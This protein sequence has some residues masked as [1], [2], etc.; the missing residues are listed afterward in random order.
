MNS[1]RGMA[2]FDRAMDVQ[3]LHLFQAADEANLFVYLP[4]RLE[5]AQRE[6]LSDGLDFSIEAVRG[7]N[8]FKPP[9]PYGVLDFRLHPMP[10]DAALLSAVQQEYPQ[11]VLVPALF[12]RGWLSLHRL[13][14]SNA[15]TAGTFV[16]DSGF[17]TP[18]PLVSNG[19]ETVRC[20]RRLTQDQL[21][22][23]KQVLQ[24]RTFTFS[25]LAEME[26]W[27]LAPRLPV[28]LDFVPADLLA[29]LFVLA[30]NEGTLAVQALT[31]FW[32]QDSSALPV[33]PLEGFDAVE[34]IRLAQTLAARTLAEFGE[35]VAAP[36]L[37]AR[38]T[39]R[40]KKLWDPP[41]LV[42]WDL[43]QETLVP[44]LV[45][46][47]LDPFE[48]ARQAV[49]AGG[50]GVVLTETIVPALETGVVSLTLGVNLP[51]NLQGIILRLGVDLLAP[52]HPP[53]RVQ[54]L[55]A[56]VLFDDPQ[57][58]HTVNWRFSP[59]EDTIYQY[60]T[61]ALVRTA[62]GIKRLAGEPTPHAGTYLLLS[63]AD[64]PLGFIPVKASDL[65]LSEAVI[66]GV[67]NYADPQTGATLE[68]PFTLDSAH[69]LISLTLP[70]ACLAEARLR[71]QAC[72]LKTETVLPIGEF[73]ARSL[74]L[75]LFSL[76]E[77]GMHTITVEV[78]FDTPAELAAVSLLPEALLAQPEQAAVLSFT[79][80]KSTR[81]WNYLANS[82]FQAGYVYRK[83]PT[84]G[85]SDEEWSA[86]QS[87][88]SGLKIKVSE[89]NGL[90]TA[91]APPPPETRVE[92][93][94]P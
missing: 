77:Y 24:D 74:R 41:T 70:E 68:I 82:L 15:P 22:L 72:S 14:D 52:S 29:E 31:D 7:V 81:S 2:D 55:T 57:A 67:C 91:A 36:T 45:P 83:F 56:S 19:L 54:P 44:I 18:A 75:D 38:P 64:F 90:G 16:D 27:G 28:R 89:L 93:G 59:V 48:T 78:E 42:R 4:A 21:S 69:P 51:V 33:T 47:E 46:L 1:W 9:Q 26:L 94:E 10:A 40:L 13:A 88:F 66:N 8:P 30:D 35:Y 60:T 73:P 17:E 50:L 85:Q 53:E 3:G 11:A 39:C 49:E 76:P 80:A 32:M 25:A 87:P 63:V 65:L 84:A 79:P 37:P 86:V 6:S 58:L 20:I 34:R 43:G 92:R 12:T 61:F 62:A 71:L 5:I 23:L